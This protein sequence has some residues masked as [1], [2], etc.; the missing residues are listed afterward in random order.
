MHSISTALIR[1][2]TGTTLLLILSSC[3][4]TSHSWEADPEVVD[5][6]QEQRPQYRWDE[7]EVTR[8]ELPELMVTDDGDRVVSRSDWE[9]RRGEILDI[10]RDQMYGD[11]KSTRLNS[12]HVAISY[13]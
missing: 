5:R 7:S 2:F 12:S 13:A 10:F 11:R 3:G 6:W 8:F 1:L 4:T 9:K